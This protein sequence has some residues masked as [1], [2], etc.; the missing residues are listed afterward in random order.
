M[1]RILITGA[2]GF[3]GRSLYSVLIKNGYEVVGAIRSKQ[4]A[5]Y[6]NL[7][8]KTVEIGNISTST[9]WTE[10]LQGIDTII[11]LAAH[12]HIMTDKTVDSLSEFRKVNVAATERLAKQ[13]V[14][15]EVRRFIFISSI[16]VNGEGTV[17]GRPYS[18]ETPLCPL[19]PYGVSKLEA[20]GCLNQLAK[21][22]GI[23]VVNIRPPLVYG[24]GVKANFLNMI[25]WL[26]I[27][28]PLPFGAIHN[29]R[30]FVALDNLVDLIMTCIDHPAAANHTFLVSDDEDLS[31]TDLLQRMSLALGKPARL[32]PFLQGYL[33][34]E[35][36]CWVSMIL[37]NV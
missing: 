7:D 27:G 23:E 9:D 11:H 12:V 16:K 33:R 29:K 32:L 28:I 18:A 21:D 37:H 22:T 10:A 20:E 36:H 31:T 5:S 1:R 8:M 19:D 35:Q 34:L 15:S 2:N 24:P 13:A 17:L 25:R 6:S 30:S 14:D 4:S 3:V 26:T